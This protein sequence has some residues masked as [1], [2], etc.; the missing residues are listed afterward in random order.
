MPLRLSW[1]LLL[2]D[3]APR[4]RRLTGFQALERRS[5]RTWKQPT[6]RKG[7]LV[8]PTPFCESGGLTSLPPPP[9]SRL[10]LCQCFFLRN[11]TFNL[12]TERSSFGTLPPSIQLKI[13]VVTKDEISTVSQSVMCWEPPHH[14]PSTC[15]YPAACIMASFLA[16]LCMRHAGQRVTDIHLHCHPAN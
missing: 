9:R 16:P 4:K 5:G 11:I 10:W 13:Y 1:L 15:T 2:T 8:N 7:T 6:V 12:T 14:L 3:F